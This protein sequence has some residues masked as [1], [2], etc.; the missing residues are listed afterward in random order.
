[1]SRRKVV[2]NY[3]EKS[4]SPCELS[5]DYLVEDTSTSVVNEPDPTSTSGAYN[6]PEAIEHEV[7][8]Q[9]L[10]NK[11]LEAIIDRYL[12]TRK[13]SRNIFPFWNELLSKLPPSKATETEMEITN[14]IYAKV[15]AYEKGQNYS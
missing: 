10:S 13:S 1:M 2:E 14:L 8:E 9:E 15:K 5:M 7:N 3:R 12:N 4:C 6:K 11:K